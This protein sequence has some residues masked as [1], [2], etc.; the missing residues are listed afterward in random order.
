MIQEP[1]S[2]MALSCPELKLTMSRPASRKPGTGK[3]RR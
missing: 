3:C 1:P 2:A